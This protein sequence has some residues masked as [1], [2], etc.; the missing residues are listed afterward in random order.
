[1]R[2]PKSALIKDKVNIKNINKIKE[3]EVKEDYIPVET[4]PVA[5]QSKQLIAEEGYAEVTGT[6]LG[7]QSTSAKTIKIRPFITDTAKVEVHAKR[8]VPLGPNEGNI[9]VAVTISMPCYREEVV[10]VYKQVDKAVDV[11]IRNKLKAMG[12]DGAEND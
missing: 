9:T 2:Q 1:M 12:M 10:S 5:E 8:H 6:T 7:K 3:E 11:L 4:P